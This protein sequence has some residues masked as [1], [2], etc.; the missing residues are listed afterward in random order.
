MPIGWDPGDGGG[1][2]QPPRPPATE[3]R[4][5]DPEPDDPWDR[6][7]EAVP[8]IWEMW[9]TNGDERVCPIC[10]PLSGLEYQT[11]HG[12][13]PPLHPNCRCIRETSRIELLLR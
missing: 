13:T 3:P 10:G 12:P 7:R 9:R 4:P 11:G 2:G 8:V 1:G 5:P 6:W